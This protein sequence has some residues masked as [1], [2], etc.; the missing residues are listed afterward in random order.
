M[1]TL[2]VILGRA[3]SR[4]LPNKNILPLSGQPMIG[5][6]IACARTSRSIDHLVVSTDGDAIAEVA[7]DYGVEVVLRPAELANDT[8][9]VDAAAR[10][11]LQS[12]ETSHGEQ[13]DAVVILYGNVPLRPADLVDRAVDKLHATGCDSVQSVY[14]VGK[15]HPYWMKKLGGAGSD[16]IEPYQPNAVYRRQDLPAV[17]MLDGG[18][19]VVTRT[20]LF[21]EH[22]E[23]AHAF[24]GE[25]RR[26]IVT[27]P[28]E[29]VDIDDARDLQIAEASMRQ[30][31]AGQQQIAVHI[32]NTTLEPGRAVYVIA[33]LGVNHDGS[34]DRA[35][36]LTRAATHAGADAVKLQLFDAATLLSAEAELAGYQRASA[37][38]PLAMLD[39]LQLDVDAMRRVR[40]L[41]HELGIGF[42][43]SC[44]S[45]DLIESLRMLD[46]DAIKI[47][48]PD[49]V[50][51]PLID[52]VASLD[53]PLIVSVGAAESSEL[54]PMKARLLG[55]PA[56]IMHCVSAYPVPDDQA[57]IAR[58]K[59]VAWPFVPGY[60]DHTTQLASGM[61]AAA[62]GATVLEKHLTYDRTAPGPDHAASCDPSQFARYVEMA[63]LGIALSGGDGEGNRRVLP[64]EADVRRVS[65]Q[66]LCA[67]RDLPSGHVIRRSDITVKRPGTG[68]PARRLD[69]VMGRTLRR[70]VEANHLL[71]EDD[72]SW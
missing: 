26:A 11:A 57:D 1:R 63:R 10:H 37:T 47:A 4:G 66:S 67:V 7:R 38:D 42:I 56:V 19:I 9:T 50:N 36:E 15:T 18:I 45:I 12:T 34:V 23:E 68:I 59:Q 35:L 25:D 64:C 5:W 49:C 24:L 20:S 3:G 44:F 21:T 69:A 29:V 31:L 58:V 27:I 40:S 61:V 13:F 71:H 53:K 17:Y 8:A 41:A 2:G 30:H 60:S 16:V 46:P 51:L 28:G 65:R 54:G 33:E 55:R 14:P 62:C 22:P 32:G 72:L 70:N 43:V 39:A 48:S 6:T 52:V